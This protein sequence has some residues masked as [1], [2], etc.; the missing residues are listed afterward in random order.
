VTNPPLGAID[1]DVHAALPGSHVLLPYLDDYWREH[2]VM[3]GLDRENLNTSN[4][5]PN[6]PLSGRPDWRPAKGDPGTDLDLLRSQALDGFGT[7][8]AILNV[9]HGAQIMF[10]E[11]LSAALCRGINDWLAAEWLD[12]DPRLRASI[13]VPLHSPELAAQEIERKAADPRFVQVL[14][15]AMAEMPLGRRQN[16]PIYRAAQRH[17]LPIGIHAGSSF[18]NPTTSIGW[19]SYLL[20]DYVAQSAGFAG[21]LTSLVSEGVFVE[22]P[23]LKVVLLESGVTWLPAY[24]WRLNKTWRGIRAEVPWL[25]RAPSDYIR[26]HVR[27]TIQPFDRPPEQRQLE[28]VMEQIGSDEMLLFSTDYPHWHFDGHDALPDGLPAHLV[29]KLLV[30]NPLNTYSRLS[31]EPAP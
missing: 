14:L 17:D 7:R 12:K 18:R 25:D 9:I 24:L 20:E 27:L 3:R 15:L 6:A 31:K 5:P 10:S 1:C 16:W 29:R 19:P 26:E 13:V 28:R 23:S 11:D 2:V 21:T 8:F 22:F 30:D 4:Y